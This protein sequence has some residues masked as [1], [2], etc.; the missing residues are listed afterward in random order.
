MHLLKPLPAIRSQR[1]STETRTL[2]LKLVLDRVWGNVPAWPVA[3]YRPTKTGGR[4]S[5]SA[6]I[7]S[8]WSSER[9]LTR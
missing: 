5:L 2:E 9:A 8:L 4:F 6:R 3:G 1:Y 7:A